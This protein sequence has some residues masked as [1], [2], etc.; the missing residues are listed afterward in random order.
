M[1]NM[2]LGSR[3]R[4]RGTEDTRVLKVKTQAKLWYSYTLRSTL[5]ACII[6]KHD[7]LVLHIIHLQHTIPWALVLVAE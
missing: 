1:R 7:E 2:V 4:S 6:T 3:R 5:H